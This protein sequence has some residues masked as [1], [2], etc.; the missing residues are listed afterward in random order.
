MIVGII[1]FFKYQMQNNVQEVQECDAT[2][3]KCLFFSRAHKFLF[4]IITTKA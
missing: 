3:V 4:Q 2:K 1:N